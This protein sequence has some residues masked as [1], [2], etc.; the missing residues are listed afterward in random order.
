MSEQHQ[1]LIETDA[2]TNQPV[3]RRIVLEFGDEEK[4]NAIVEVNKK[5]VQQLKPH[6]AE[7]TLV[8]PSS[9]KLQQFFASRKC[10]TKSC[11]KVACA[12]TVQLHAATLLHKRGLNKVSFRVIQ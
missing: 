5:L 4:K 11:D 2:T 7:G 6:Q 10:A 8:S 12:A 3:C 9:V 1:I